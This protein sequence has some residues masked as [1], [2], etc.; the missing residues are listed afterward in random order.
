VFTS[1]DLPDASDKTADGLGH[2][3]R[4]AKGAGRFA[5]DDSPDA[6]VVRPLLNGVS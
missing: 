5:C 1:L 4:R 6:F 2:D 3:V